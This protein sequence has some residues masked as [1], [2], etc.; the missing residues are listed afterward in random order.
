MPDQTD[1]QDNEG[2]A[3]EA[4]SHDSARSEKATSIVKRNMWWAAGAG[5]LP[6]PSIELVAITAVELK[7][8]NELSNLY[9]VPF[10]K[11]LAKSAVASLVSGLGSVA[12]G[13]LLAASA[14]RH[15]PVL[16]LPIALA[17]VPTFA[18]GVTWAVGRVFTA[19]FAMGGTLLDFDA[20]KVREFFA[21]EFENG[22]QHARDAVKSVKT[23]AG[24]NRA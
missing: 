24:L 7:L 5:L 1:I 2:H 16:G 9:D 14:L 23:G 10:R 6:I 11:D 12:L 22:V 20:V 19:H 21:A 18:A 4:A 3:S 8:I 17:S 13:N 15:V